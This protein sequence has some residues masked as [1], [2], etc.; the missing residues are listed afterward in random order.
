MQGRTARILSTQ[1]GKRWG[2]WRER[3]ARAKRCPKKMAGILLC[4]GATL[5]PRLLQTKSERCGSSAEAT[6]SSFWSTMMQEHPL[7]SEL[8]KLLMHQ[9]STPMTRSS[10]WWM[11]Q[12]APSRSEGSLTS[13]KSARAAASWGT[14]SQG[15]LG[16]A[17]LPHIPT[18]RGFSTRM[19]GESDTSPIAPR[20]GRR[21]DS[22]A[23]CGRVQGVEKMFESRLLVCPRLPKMEHD[24]ANQAEFA[25]IRSEETDHATITYLTEP[26]ATTGH[27]RREGSRLSRPQYKCRR[28]GFCEFEERDRKRP[29]AEAAR[30]MVAWRPTVRTEEQWGT[31]W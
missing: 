26:F 5:T 29:H 4:L 19:P 14:F 21:V 25:E 3:D 10:C 1:L 20:V 9:M 27:H 15:V 24:T 16:S 22:P 8:V 18:K 6:S 17:R 30:V 23:K 31:E 2:F 28:P 12:A 11:L 7:D 13:R